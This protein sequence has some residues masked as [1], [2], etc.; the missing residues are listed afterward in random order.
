MS[1]ESRR[2]SLERAAALKEETRGF[3]EFKRD[4]EEKRKASVRRS[5]EQKKRLLEYFGAGEED[6]DD[7]RFQVG[8]RISDVDVLG[9]FLRLDPERKAKIREVAGTYRWACTPY[10]LS[11]MDPEDE[12]PG[13]Q[14]F[15]SAASASTVAAST[16]GESL[17]G[18]V[19]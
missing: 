2:I 10:Y 7:W 19:S 3:S 1:E 4:F 11:L 9:E 13:P 6:W 14:R 5:M 12:S 15:L 8:N 16:A 18:L 17:P